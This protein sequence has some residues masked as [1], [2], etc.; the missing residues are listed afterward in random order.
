VSALS[1]IAVALGLSRQATATAGQAADMAK[2]VFGGGALGR[3][4]DMIRGHAWG[5]LVD[6]TIRDIAACI[7]IA[8]PALASVAPMAAS[9]VV[10]ARHHPEAVESLAM[11]KAAGNMNSGLGV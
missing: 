2:A 10:W 7:A 3:I 11:Q 5:D 8:D 1:T 4:A 9:L 6:L